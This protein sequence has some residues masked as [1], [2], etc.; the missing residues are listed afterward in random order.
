[1]PRR[2]AAIFADLPIIENTFY[3][4]TEGHWGFKPT[5][6]AAILE[7]PQLSTDSTITS[8]VP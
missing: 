4:L 7:E 6:V 1:M 5:E 8:P 3:S 2:T